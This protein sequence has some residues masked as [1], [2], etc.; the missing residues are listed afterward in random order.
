MGSLSVRLASRS[1]TPLYLIFITEVMK[2]AVND[3]KVFGEMLENLEAV[4][5][6]IARYAILE[7][8][9]S[10]H[11]FAART[12][13]ERALVR[14]YAEILIFLGQAKKH[15]QRPAKGM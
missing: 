5:Q 1:N 14:L 11:D 3:K 7:D 4:S 12:E 10:A 2:M 6:L 15:F 13:F 9:S 8:L